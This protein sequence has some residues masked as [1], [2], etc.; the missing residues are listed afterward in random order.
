MKLLLWLKDWWHEQ[1]T[2]DK[3]CIC[4]AVGELIAIYLLNFMVS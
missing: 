3:A 2:S 1:T 4:F